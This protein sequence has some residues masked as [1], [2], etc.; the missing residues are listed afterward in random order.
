MKITQSQNLFNKAKTLIPGGVNSPVRAFKNVRGSPLFIKRA[1]GSYIIDV[2]NHKYIDYVCAW[3]P[4]ILGHAPKCIQKEI[5]KRLSRGI[6]FGAPHELEIEMAEIIIKAFP[7]IEKVRMVNSGTEATMSCVRL[8]R[9]FTQREKIVKFSGC[10]H[11]HADTLLFEAGSGGLTHSL[12]NSLGV[13]KALA[14][15]VITLPFNSIEK[16]KECFKQEGKNIAGVIIEPY[17]ANAGLLLP[18]NGYLEEL[19]KI[20]E[21]HGSVLIFDE[22][23]TGFRISEGGVQKITKIKPDITALG[24]VIGGGLPVG[25]FGGK[26]KI[27]DML[28]PEGPVY[29]AGTLS[30]NP[31]SLIAGITQIREMQR[32]D[33]WD[34]LEMLGTL[35]EEKIRNLQTKGIPFQF[36]RAGSIFSF[37]F[38]EEKVIDLITA[39]TSDTRSFRKFF[40]EILN[41][42]IY[43]APSPFEAGFISTAHSK[44]DIEK[45]VKAMG[46][47]MGE[48]N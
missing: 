48:I 35:L 23:M 11:G 6:S 26:A 24:K 20:T 41:R 17:P 46:K 40:H 10:Y 21:S 18:Q 34:Y 30:G 3:G 31:I 43:I 4:A 7:S 39:T 8:A 19:R 25:A 13:P 38:T 2:D 27:M 12:P 1:K 5:R 36:H 9:A 15:D 16:L 28:S 47:A 37:F 42:G 32:R 22:V 44:R 33:G 29:Q 14:E 45:T